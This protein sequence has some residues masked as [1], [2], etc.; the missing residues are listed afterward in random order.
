M[1]TKSEL[2]RDASNK[3][4]EQARLER[5]EAERVCAAAREARVL[6]QSQLGR[7]RATDVFAQK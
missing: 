7:I 1:L 3:L 4:C 6:S 2:L 5:E